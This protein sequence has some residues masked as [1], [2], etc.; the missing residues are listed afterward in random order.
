MIESLYSKL[1][2]PTD[3]ALQRVVSR[4]QGDE[5][6]IIWSENNG[7][8]VGT[9]IMADGINEGFSVESAS[10]V[11]DNSEISFGQHRHYTPE[12][13]EMIAIFRRVTADNGQIA[14]GVTDELNGILGSSVNNQYDLAD[15]T[16]N[17]NKIFRHNAATIPAS[18][19]WLV[20]FQN[21]A[22]LYCRL[23]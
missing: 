18:T 22:L 4:F 7:S 23:N 14:C 5:L 13:F 11:N 12:N 20:K 1:N 10:G 16:V 19:P 9:F 2:N 17:T 3:I 21:R 8:G 15:S 6:D